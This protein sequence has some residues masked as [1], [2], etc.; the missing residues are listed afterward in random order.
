LAVN[1]GTAQAIGLVLPDEL[2]E[3]A[4]R[5]FYGAPSAIGSPEAPQPTAAPTFMPSPAATE[6][7]F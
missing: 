5:I 1:V 6:R 7:T 2:I 4:D 3:Q